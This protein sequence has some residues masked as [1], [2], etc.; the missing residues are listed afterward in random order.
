MRTQPMPQLFDRDELQKGR[1]V[2]AVIGPDLAGAPDRE[3]LV[4]RAHSYLQNDLS[5]T[6]AVIH[7]DDE[8]DGVMPPIEFDSA[9]VPVRVA[10]RIAGNIIVPLDGR[11][12]L[13]AADHEILETFAAFLSVGISNI[14]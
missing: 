10:G 9:R 8:V 13:V 11:K 6:G 12:S 4:S 5:Y 2:L 1:R 3:T 14:K 7:L